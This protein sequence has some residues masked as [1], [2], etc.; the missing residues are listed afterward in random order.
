M[1]KKKKDH[2][3]YMFETD[4][5]F[6][7]HPSE[8]EPNYSNAY[9]CVSYSRSITTRY[10]RRKQTM[11]IASLVCVLISA[12]LDRDTKHEEKDERDGAVG[13]ITLW[14]LLMNRFLQNE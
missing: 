7:L 9:L 14:S 5:E 3:F 12:S 6:G 10:A 13:I 8:A 1:Q 11:Q 2:S 4:L